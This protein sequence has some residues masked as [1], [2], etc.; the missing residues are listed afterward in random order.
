MNNPYEELAKIMPSQRV[1]LLPHCLRQSRSCH[2]T[3]DAN[4][5]HCAGCNPECSV[6]VLRTA[7]SDLDYKGICVAPG[8]SLALKYIREKQPEAIVAVAC[9]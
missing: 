8:G 9:D 1:L 2:G 3:Y 5:L 6:N 4:G 7:A